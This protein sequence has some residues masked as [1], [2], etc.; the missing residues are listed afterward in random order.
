VPGDEHKKKEIMLVED[1]GGWNRLDESS[2]DVLDDGRNYM[3][4]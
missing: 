4:I 1:E 3:Y 2:D